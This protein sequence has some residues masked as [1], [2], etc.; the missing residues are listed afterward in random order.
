MFP[1]LKAYF[2]LFCFI[3]NETSMERRRYKRERTLNEL[4]LTA[5]KERI[6]YVE[7]WRIEEGGQGRERESVKLSL[8]R[9]DI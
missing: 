3:N 2:D 5:I 6:E 7:R 4:T 1:N 9:G 8:P